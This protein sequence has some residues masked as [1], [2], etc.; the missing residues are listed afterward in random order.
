MVERLL[1]NDLYNYLLELS[2]TLKIKKAEKLSES[3]QFTSRFASGSRSTT[4]ALCR[5]SNCFE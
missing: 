4:G 3:V 2:K 5:V 1:A